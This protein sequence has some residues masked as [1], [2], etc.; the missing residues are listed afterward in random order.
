MSSKTPLSD[1]TS[2][3]QQAPTANDYIAAAGTLR[4]MTAELTFLMAG[5]ELPGG[6][7]IAARHVDVQGKKIDFA[8]EDAQGRKA[9]LEAK[10][11][12]RKS[13]ERALADIRNVA[14]ASAV[15]H[16][17][18]QLRA[19]SATGVPVYLAVLDVIGERLTDLRRLLDCHELDD[20]IVITFP[21]DKFEATFEQLRAGL[22]IPAVVTPALADRIAE[23]DHE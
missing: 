9:K 12:S 11:W 8:L 17:L 16:M 2:S 22:R 4:S 13:W 23:L 21:Q 14:P 20:V 15:G 3:S 1:D 6:L 19:A 18:A 10:A 5:I 7:E